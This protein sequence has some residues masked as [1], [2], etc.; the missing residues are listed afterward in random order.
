V[1]HAAAGGFQADLVHR[2]AEA[3]AV[4]GLV[5]GVGI[6]AD[7]LHAELLQRA[8]TEQR[9]RGVERRLAAHGGQQGQR[10]LRALGALTLDDAGDDFGRDRLDIGGVGHLV[11]GHDRGRV[12]V[13]QDDP[14][15]FF[16]QRL[17]RLRA[18]IVELAS[19]TDDDG[20][21]P[22]TRIELMSV[23]FGIRRGPQ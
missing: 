18:R 20:P 1:G 5:D 2:L 10:V 21:A 11:V 13:D 19:L 8:V 12:R 7:H 6:G 22:M 4:L 15:T 9:Q 23:R 16:L 14:V 3:L 17:D